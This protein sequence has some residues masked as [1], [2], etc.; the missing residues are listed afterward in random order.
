[1]EENLY[2]KPL[3]NDNPLTFTIVAKDLTSLV[4]SGAGDVQVEALSTPS[5]DLNL[6]GAGKVSQNQ[7]NTNDLKITI[8]GLGGIDITG[9]IPQA[10]IDIS[11]AGS[12]N[13]A[14]LQIRLPKSPS[15]A[16]A[17]QRCG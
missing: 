12:V 8:S 14:D 6:S 5:M 4:V 17:A 11:G 1:M 7:I 3:G 16:W 10:T 2:I 9:Q 13:G 15:P